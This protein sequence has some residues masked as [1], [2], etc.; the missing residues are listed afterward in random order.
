[1]SGTGGSTGSGIGC[2]A[3]G[4]TAAANIPAAAHQLPVIPRGS[5][6][7]PRFEKTFEVYRAELELYLGERESWGV[8]I[9]AEIRH[10]T[11]QALQTQFDERD[12]FA[13]ATI[14]RGLR[15]CQTTMQ[16]KCVQWLQQPRCGHH[17]GGQDP[18][19]FFLC[20][21]LA[22]AIVPVLTSSKRVHGRIPEKDGKL[23]ATITKHG[24]RACCYGR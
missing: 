17:L 6:Q 13:R 21:I 8:V 16:P 12:R 19:R 10:A 7:P 9:E 24:R 22:A 23:S 14:L 20:G 5:I 18:T 2:N 11:N 1:M 3:G 15:W 4:G